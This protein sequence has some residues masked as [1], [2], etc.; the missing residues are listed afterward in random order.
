[1]LLEPTSH[2]IT[3]LLTPS[4]GRVRN[5]S[6]NAAAIPLLQLGPERLSQNRTVDFASRRQRADHR[7]N[8][9]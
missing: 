3:S 5:Y 4:P 1:M 9:F 8:R 2:P 7:G 6:P